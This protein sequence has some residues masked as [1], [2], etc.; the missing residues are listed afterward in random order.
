MVDECAP[1]FDHLPDQRV[2]SLEDGFNLILQEAGYDLGRRQ[3]NLRKNR[4][5][6]RI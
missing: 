4:R 6:I 5:E 3:E 2:P 1:R